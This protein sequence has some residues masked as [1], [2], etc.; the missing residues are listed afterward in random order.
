MLDRPLTPSIT[1]TI[2]R[3]T[4]LYF[5]FITTAP[6]DL[7]S[8]ATITLLADSPAG[9]VLLRGGPFQP[10]HNAQQVRRTARARGCPRMRLAVRQIPRETA[11]SDRRR[12]PGWPAS[13]RCSTALARSRPPDPNQVAA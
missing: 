8:S 9:V 12:I 4:R 1:V 7:D 3:Y 2:C 5:A 11:T 10:R 13:T 6:V